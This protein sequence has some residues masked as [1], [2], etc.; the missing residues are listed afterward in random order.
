[1]FLT[2]EGYIKLYLTN[3]YPGTSSLTSD[4]KHNS[5]Y[6]V[7]TSRSSLPEHLLSPEQLLCL[8]LQSYEPTFD[9]Y[10]SDVF[11]MGMLVLG[12]VFLDDPKFYYN[13]ETL[14]V[15]FGRVKYSLAMIKGRYS[16]EL[17]QV[18]KGMLE[19]D[20]EKRIGF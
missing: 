3:L 7:L 9:V 8:S 17:E 14:E 20:E 13:Q 15:N 11:S 18:L 6:T 5:Y 19:Q 10:K 4:N 12:L 16:P 2:P 1:M